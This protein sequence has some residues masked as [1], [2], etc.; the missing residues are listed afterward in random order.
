V[1]RLNERLAAPISHSA[2]FH[3]GCTEDNRKPAKQ[4]RETDSEGNPGNAKDKPKLSV[5]PSFVEPPH[6]ENR[7]NEH[8][9]AATYDKHFRNKG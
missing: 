3:D 5:Y 2:P 9:D 8:R 4:E 7:G 6:H 1:V